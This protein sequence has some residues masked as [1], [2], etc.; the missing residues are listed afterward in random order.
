MSSV[1]ATLNLG[2]PR[3]N[4]ATMATR[5]RYQRIAALYDL[6]GANSEKRFGPWR[7]K[8]WSSVHAASILEVGVGT[9]RNMPYY[10]LHASVTAI[11]L[12]PA[13]LERAQARASEM[14]LSGQLTLQLGD[15][16]S[17]EFASGSFDAAVATCV[18]CSVPDPVLGLR[19]IKRVVR[20]GGQILLLEHM[21]SSNPVAGYLMD[22]LNPL[23][24]RIAGANINRRTLDNVRRAGLEF[25][26]I[27]DLGMGGIIKL[28]VV[29]VPL[30]EISS[31]SSRW[32]L[33]PAVT[34]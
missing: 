4:A 32:P 6:M 28:I 17:L 15:V 11:D 10:P 1:D 13:M 26:R 8:L 33:S 25:E 14:G 12:T 23:V 5:R 7:A 9:G 27:E 16:Q 21:R 2:S 30:V 24:V 3:E 31:A 20:P 29:R 19:E 18:F 22:L 34:F